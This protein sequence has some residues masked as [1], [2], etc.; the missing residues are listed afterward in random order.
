MIEGCC[1]SDLL[2]TGVLSLG[3]ATFGEGFASTC[4]SFGA[5]NI[6]VRA[7]ANPLAASLAKPPQDL[8]VLSPTNVSVAKSRSASASARSMKATCGPVP[9]DVG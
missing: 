7:A 8:P 4:N 5:S 3:L 2:R 6:S 9:E 1:A